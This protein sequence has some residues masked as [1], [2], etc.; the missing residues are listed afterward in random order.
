MPDFLREPSTQQAI[1]LCILG[2]GMALGAYYLVGRL[3]GGAE[4][5]QVNTSDMLTKFREMHASGVL[6]DEEYRTIKTNLSARLQ[7]E[8]KDSERTG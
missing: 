4:E 2:I 6:S 7:N 3:R 8:I 1:W 5:D